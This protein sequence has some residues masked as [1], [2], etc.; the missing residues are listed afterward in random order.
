MYGP[1]TIRT[2]MHLTP[3]IR[4]AC[5]ED[6]P[7]IRAL[8][9]RYGLM[10]RDYEEWKNLWVNNPV[11][12]QTRDWP[13]GWVLETKNKEIVGHI[14]NVPLSYEFCGHQ[15]IT[16]TGHALV[17]DPG[18]RGYSLPLLSC[19]YNQK[20]IDLFLGTT[21]NS[22]ATK[23]HELFRARRVPVGVWNESSFWITD[24]PGFLASVLALKGMRL[25]KPLAYPLSV[26]LQLKQTLSRWAFKAGRNGTDISVCNTFDDRFDKFWY[27]LRRNRLHSLLATRSREMLEWHFQSA[28]AQNRAWVVTLHNRHGINGYAIFYRQDK[29]AVHLKRL[30]LIDFQTLDGNNEL[31]APILCWA[32]EQCRSRGIHMLESIG[33]CPEKQRIIDE[34]RPLKRKLSCWLYLYKTNDKVLAESLQDAQVWDP[35]GYDG[36]ASL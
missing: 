9:V 31:L 34:L 3:T 15:I 36:D 10:S 8:E 35:C 14:G 2:A 19:F 13:I 1:A 11:Y 32:F 23:A 12:N 24:C 33:F 18:Y 26:G 17:V 25:L 29:D 6:Y 28:L 7:G 16:T 4:E 30:N 27:Q 21:V 5:F 20:N 22:S